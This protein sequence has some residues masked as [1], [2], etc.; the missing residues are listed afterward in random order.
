MKINSRVIALSVINI[1]IVIHLLGQSDLSIQAQVQESAKWYLAISDGRSFKYIG[2]G[3]SEFGIGSK[4]QFLGDV[5]GDAKT[6]AVVFY[7]NDG[8]W[9]VASANLDGHRFNQP[10]RWLLGFGIGSDMQYLADINGDG[11][12][13]AVV[14]YSRQRVWQVAYS[15]GTSFSY[16]GIPYSNTN[17]AASRFLADLNGDRVAD[18][19]GGFVDGRVSYSTTFAISDKVDILTSQYFKNSG[20]V[21]TEKQ[22]LIADVNGDRSA[23][24]VLFASY[25]DLGLA[26]Y[27]ITYRSLEIMEEAGMPGAKSRLYPLMYRTF[28][29]LK[30]FRLALNIV[31]GEELTN[32]YLPQILDGALEKDRER[33][34]FTDWFVASLNTGS[35]ERLMSRPSYERAD[36]S[37]TQAFL[38]DIDG[39]GKADPIL[40]FKKSGE[41]VA[42]TKRDK[43]RVI[44]S[45]TSW[46]SNFGIGSNAQFFGDVNG[47]GL[48]DLVVYTVAKV[49]TERQ[50]DGKPRAS[51]QD[52]TLVSWQT[53]APVFD[54]LSE[55]VSKLRSSIG[56]KYQDV[57]SLL[58]TVSDQILTLQAKW[59]SQRKP[60]SKLY[61]E[62]LEDILAALNKLDGDKTLRGSAADQREG[63][64]NTYQALWPQKNTG[65][66]SNK[67]IVL[68]AL[69]TVSRDLELKSEYEY[70]DM[71]DVLVYTK[72]NKQVVNGFNI[73]WSTVFNADNPTKWVLFTTSSSPAFKNLPPGLYQ[74]GLEKGKGEPREIGGRTSDGNLIV[75]QDVEIVL[76]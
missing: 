43:D 17:F 31:I 36:L 61:L 1:L 68:K 64:I 39:D 48:A 21:I 5:D 50:S 73:W 69:K 72:K 22:E 20:L 40:F 37:S 35:F 74:I 10:R 3:I 18:W 9:Y 54:S 33:S 44:P 41:W 15:T 63:L 38:A 46:I 66:A 6:D 13:D 23:D 27:T 19:V 56:R 60:I 49:P 52:K 30:E 53:S 70:G 8:S 25:L 45:Y 58:V 34:I 42:A 75:K 28:H 76:P 11:K 14:C 65:S 2:I 26:W 24:I 12:L 67:T 55:S 47:D 7:D 59:K 32:R 51:N 4:A 57:N 29:G 62:S 71:V 16:P